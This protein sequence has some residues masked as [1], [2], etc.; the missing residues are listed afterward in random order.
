[1]PL[2]ITGLHTFSAYQ[3]WLGPD[4]SRLFL[5]FPLTAN[6]HTN[7]LHC[8]I[9]NPLGSKCYSAYQHRLGQGIL[10]TPVPLIYVGWVMTFL[11][12]AKQKL[13]VKEGLETSAGKAE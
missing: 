5:Y 2:S 6:E 12:C 10:L 7:K 9:L 13:L 11:F 8:L 1:M 4:I 3:K